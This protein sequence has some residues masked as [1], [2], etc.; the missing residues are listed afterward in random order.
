MVAIIVWE[1]MTSRLRGNYV[2]Q[3]ILV[4]QVSLHRAFRAL[5]LPIVP[6]DELGLTGQFGVD[7][8]TAVQASRHIGRGERLPR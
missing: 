2:Y 5:H 8:Q 3:P 1:G 6:S 4:S 7:G